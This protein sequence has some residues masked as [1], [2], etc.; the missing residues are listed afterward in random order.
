MTLTVKLDLDSVKVNHQAK[1]LRQR[2]F[3]SKVIVQTDRHTYTHETIAL[4]SWTIKV[5]GKYSELQ[6]SLWRFQL[7]LETAF[8]TGLFLSAFSC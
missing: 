5:V 2:S 4:P 8:K 3:S 7:N 6:R 1:Y